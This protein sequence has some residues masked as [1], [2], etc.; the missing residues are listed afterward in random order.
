MRWQVNSRQMDLQSR[1]RT[2]IL[3]LP[4][5]RGPIRRHRLTAPVLVMDQ[6]GVGDMG[7]LFA[8][9][10]GG[11]SD[12]ISG[13]LPTRKG[14]LWLTLLT[15]RHRNWSGAGWSETKSMELVS[16]KKK[17]T[18]PRRIWCNVS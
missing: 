7:S 10:G 15:P 4:S 3:S 14:A 13:P 18:T 6:D 8:A 12:Q 9:A 2:R 11:D 1:W 5:T 17:L 16:R